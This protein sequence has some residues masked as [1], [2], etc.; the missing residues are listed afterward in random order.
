MARSSISTDS[1]EAAD[2]EG[3]CRRMPFGWSFGGA[4]SAR[5]L[6][7]ARSG[8]APSSINRVTIVEDLESAD[9]KREVFGYQ[10]SVVAADRWL[11]R[12]SLTQVQLA[13]RSSSA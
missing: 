6:G 8:L 13:D 3:G 10:I 9:Q 11:A 7:R 1:R 2:V 5:V 12:G 4:K